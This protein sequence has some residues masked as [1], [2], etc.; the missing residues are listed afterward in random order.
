MSLTD[1]QI[2]DYRGLL[3]EINTL[4]QD[5]LLALWRAYSHQDPVSL[6]EALRQGVPEIIEMYRAVAADTATLFYAETQGLLFSAEDLTK[7]TTINRQQVVAN[8]R[9]ALFN[10]GNTEVLGLIAGIIQ[11]HVVDGSRQFALDGFERAGAGWYRAARENACEFCRMLATW[12]ATEWGPYTSADAAVTVGKGATSRRSSAM[13]KGS[14]FHKNCM[15]LPVRASEYEVPEH[16][17][18]WA[19]QYY[20]ATD[21]VGNSYDYRAILAYMRQMNKA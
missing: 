5:D 1:D 18:E 3:T 7:A 19:E 6:Y 2:K 21:A 11:K 12:G 17:N 9:W 13:P 10:P 4:A 8:L 14:T 20:A 16:V 15:C